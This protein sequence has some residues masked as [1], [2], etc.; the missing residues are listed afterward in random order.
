LSEHTPGPWVVDATKATGPYSVLTQ[1]EAIPQ[2]DCI[3]C[4]FGESRRR[5]DRARLEADARLIA[6]APD[7]LT[8]AIKVLTSDLGSVL[9]LDSCGRAIGIECDCGIEDLER[10]VFKATGNPK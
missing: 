6:A 7:L 3:V 5:G 1:S 2:K 8:A 4:S 9:H 10:A